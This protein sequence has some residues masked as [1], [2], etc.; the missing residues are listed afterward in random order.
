SQEWSLV[1]DEKNNQIG[2]V[3]FTDPS[4]AEQGYGGAVHFL[5]GID[6]SGKIFG[7]VLTDH[8]ETPD[9]VAWIKEKGFL[10][11]WN[12]LSVSEALNKKVDTVSGATETT[13]AIIRA[14]QKRLSLVSH[15][16]LYFMALASSPWILG[17]NVLSILALCFSLLMNLKNG[18]VGFS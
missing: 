15:N 8:N 12:H 2:K 6:K 10:E 4:V 18:V 11:L 13:S 7:L 16:K 1:F 3:I 5:I 9:V 17:K 14:F